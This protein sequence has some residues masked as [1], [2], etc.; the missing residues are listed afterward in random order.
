MCMQQLSESELRDEVRRIQAD[1]HS[2]LSAIRGAVESKGL[3]VNA[4]FQS[5]A[6]FDGPVPS[7]VKAAGFAEHVRFFGSRD[8]MLQSI[9][10]SA[11]PE[12]C[13]LGV[14]KGA[15]S[16]RML[17][18]FSPRVFH[19]F[20]LQFSGLDPAVRSEAAVVLHEGDSGTAIAT[21]ADDSIDYAY[22]DGDHSYAGSRRDIIGILPKV[23]RGGYIQLNDYTPWSVLSGF[24]YGV[25]A[26]VHEVLNRGDA[27]MVGFA[28]QP[29]GHHDVLLRKS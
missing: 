16:K 6:L 13:E 4:F 1:F 21:L 3:D 7:Q 14:W 15:F 17:K 10:L 20:D 9:Q 24:P 2:R 22:V 12:V 27:T 5:T 18:H 29:F 8:E 26:N 28:L 25:M 11:G 19:L 23:K